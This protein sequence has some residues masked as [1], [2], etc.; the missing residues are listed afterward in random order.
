MIGRGA[1]GNPF[2]FKQINDYLTTG[3]Y[4]NYPAKNRLEAFN[5]YVEYA[6]THKIKFAN[7]KRQAMRFT[8]GLAAGA[9][10]RSKI[11]LAKTIDEIKTIIIEVS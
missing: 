9:Q 10:L 5:K 1:M 7:I 3:S 6:T 8:K 11:M 2:L 4:Q